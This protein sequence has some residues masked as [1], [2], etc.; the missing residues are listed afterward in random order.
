MQTNL[1]KDFIQAARVIAIGLVLGLGIG[2]AHADWTAPL[3]TPP[4]CNAGEPGCDA[5]INVSTKGQMKG[6]LSTGAIS[7]L[8]SGDAILDLW[9]PGT[10][11]ALEAYT[12]DVTSP[13]INA[14]GGITSMG[15]SNLVGNVVSGWDPNGP[16]GA[17]TAA[18]QNPLISATFFDP[19]YMKNLVDIVG[20]G[21]TSTPL[22]ID[23]T[24]QSGGNAINING[25]TNKDSVGVITNKPNFYFYNYGS[26]NQV[27]LQATKVRLQDGT[28]GAGKVLTSD[29]NGISSWQTPANGITFQD[30][31]VDCSWSGSDVSNQCFHTGWAGSAV[32]DTKMQARAWCNNG[33]V[34][35][36]G[37][38]DCQHV[39]P[40]GVIGIISAPIDGNGTEMPGGQYGY[41]TNGTNGEHP[42]GWEQEC[43]AG[44]AHVDVICVLQN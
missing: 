11:L 4:T 30:I 6:N 16:E 2:F 35:I 12:N 31:H 21:G 43:F 29:A 38:G 22:S 15:T 26:G 42:I 37:G 25:P 8:K 5:P 32:G 3:H 27:T 20:A 36:S 13:A 39:D 33:Y 14:D 41:S 9:Q 7:F 17:G 44:D 23:L 19:V 34:A 10:G 40:N 18:Y 24:N 1:Q 28:Q